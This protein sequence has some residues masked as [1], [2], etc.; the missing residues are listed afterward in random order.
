MITGSD[1]VPVVTGMVWT[2]VPARVNT[3]AH[4]EQIS[5]SV[6]LCQS[7]LSVEKPIKDTSK[8][9]KCFQDSQKIRF[10]F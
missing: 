6:C 8:A 2:V 7:C 4:N 3:G 10:F 5:V 1:T 9:K